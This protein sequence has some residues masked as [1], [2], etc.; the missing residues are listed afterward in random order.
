MKQDW[1]FGD[2]DFHVLELRQ[3][4][5]RTHGLTDRVKYSELQ[6]YPQYS[7]SFASSSVIRL[8]PWEHIGLNEGSFLKAYGTY[9]YFERG[10]PSLVYSIKQCISP[11]TRRVN[12]GITGRGYFPAVR[13]FSYTAMFP[14]ANHA[15]FVHMLPYLEELDLQFA[16]DPQSGI[17][18]DKERTGKAELQDC[19]QEL[20]S[21]YQDIATMLN[22]FGMSEERFPQLKKFVCRDFRI[23]ALRA[24]L[25]EIF[26][27]LRLPVWVE[28]EPG[29]FTR[30]AMSARLPG[31]EG[32]S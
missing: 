8:R 1:A 29:V 13:S 14:F 10:P 17:L 3:G 20:F 21:A 26:T 9:E 18:D 24:D 11:V 4:S 7:H 22:T 28:A 16:P 23:Q 27:P 19:W 31:V 25:D 12:L 32:V 6:P 5:N 30:I 2:M 15:D